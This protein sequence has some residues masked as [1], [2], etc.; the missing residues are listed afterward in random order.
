M[1]IKI[2]Y[3]QIFI[4]LSLSS[5]NIVCIAESFLNRFLFCNKFQNPRAKA[6]KTIKKTLECFYEKCLTKNEEEIEQS[7]I[8]PKDSK[9]TEY[10]IHVYAVLELRPEFL[11]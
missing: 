10:P 4:D 2:L 6:Q 1:I 5:K 11:N 3:C 9:E 7:C 8:S